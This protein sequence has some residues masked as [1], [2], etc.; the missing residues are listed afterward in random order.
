MKDYFL[1]L[2]GLFPENQGKLLYAEG[3]H[4]MWWGTLDKMNP[5]V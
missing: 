4:P 5:F 2:K 3:K 1:K